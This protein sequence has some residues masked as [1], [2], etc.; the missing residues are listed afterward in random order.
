MTIRCILSA[1]ITRYTDTR[2]TMAHVSWL[3]TR[4]RQGE[5]VGAYPDSTHIQAMLLRAMR[6]GVTVTREEF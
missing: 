4:K 1:R 6:E 5:T 2:Q 3:D